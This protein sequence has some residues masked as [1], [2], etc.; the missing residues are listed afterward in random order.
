MP[1]PDVEPPLIG[2]EEGGKD[3]I[4]DT[5]P[6]LF[7]TEATST[8]AAAAVAGALFAEAAREVA[9]EEAGKAGVSKRKSC[10]G[11][12][13]LIPTCV[14][15]SI[16][17]TITRY[18]CSWG[19]ELPVAPWLGVYR[20][21]IFVRGEARRGEGGGAVYLLLTLVI[22]PMNTRPLPEGALFYS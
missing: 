3:L 11:A 7:F 15:S 5:P 10:V 6:P 19:D 18:R 20:V 14:M 13:G 17:V 12:E 16:T 8:A 22:R 1:L 21:S 9:T 4:D 2:G